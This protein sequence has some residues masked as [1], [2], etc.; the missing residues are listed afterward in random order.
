M[1]FEAIYRRSP[2]LQGNI[3]D[4]LH[5]KL[6]CRTVPVF[7]CHEVYRSFFV[8]TG[9]QRLREGMKHCFRIPRGE[10][11]FEKLHIDLVLF[12]PLFQGS[13]NEGECRFKIIIALVFIL[14]HQ[15]PGA[16]VVF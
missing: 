9:L 5:G 3:K 1:P 2:V 11:V 6:N 16:G 7:V 14:Y 8:V 10:A 13:G 15:F 4:R 12:R